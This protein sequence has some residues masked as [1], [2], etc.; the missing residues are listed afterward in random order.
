MS[1][2]RKIS[3]YCT[4]G[5]FLL[6]ALAGVPLAFC[7]FSGEP[8]PLY[9]LV[10]FT[11]LPALAVFS[12]GIIAAFPENLR[13]VWGNSRLRYL[14]IAAGALVLCAA[15]HLI[16]RRI[17]VEN[18]LGTLF[19]I[20]APLAVAALADEFRKLLIPFAAFGALL[21]LCSGMTSSGFTGL[22][23]NWNWT[24]GIFI[25]LL[26]GVFLLFFPKKWYVFTAGAIILFFALF[27][28]LD[29]V[30]FPRSALLAAAGA[31]VLLF[32]RRKMPEK[33]FVLL[34]TGTAI[35]AAVLF[36][37]GL[38]L[39]SL[40]DTRFQI[41]R[42]AAGAIGNNFFFGV[43]AGRFPEIIHPHLFDAG[44]FTEFTAPNIDHAHNDFL[45]LFAENGLAGAFFYLAALPVLFARREKSSAGKLG[46]WI[47]AV[48]VICGCFDQHHLSVLGAVTTALAAGLAIS[49]RRTE[50]FALPEYY[51]LTGLTAG[52]LL[53]AVALSMM[54]TVCRAT[55]LLRKGDL[56]ALK[57][58]FP[59][60][61]EYY[62][63]SM[64]IKFLPLAA[65]QAAEMHLLFFNRSESALRLLE[66]MEYLLKLKSFRHQQR[67]TGWAHFNLKN[68][69]QALEYFRKEERRSPY[70]VINARFLA[71]ALRQNRAPG[72]E[73]AQADRRFL[74]LCALRGISPQEVAAFTVRKD[75]VG[76]KPEVR[77]AYFKGNRFA[78]DG[79]FAGIFKNIAGAVGLMLAIYAMGKLLLKPFKKADLTAE[80]ACGMIISGMAALVIPPSI[81]KYPFLLLTLP[82]AYFAIAGIRRNLRT[83]LLYTL[84]FAPFFAAMLLPVS[85]WDEQV[86]QI[87][88]LKRYLAADSTLPV[89]DNPYS[90]Y[91]SL[92]QLFLMGGMRTGLWNIPAVTLWILTVI[93]TAK[94]RQFAKPYG[95]ILSAVAL[96]AVVLSPLFWN[97]IRA[98]YV[99]SIVTFFGFAGVIL[100]FARWEKP[101]WQYLF[102]G[103]MAG[104]AA[105]VKLPGVSVSLMLFVLL[106]TD[107]EKRRYAGI[108]IT[109]AI[110]AALPFYLRVWLTCGNPVYPY[111][112]G[113][114]GGSESSLAVETFYRT[115]GGN[116]GGNPFAGI[117]INLVATI[118]SDRDFDGINPGFQQLVFC[119]IIAAA[120]VKIK[121]RYTLLC[122]GVIA[123]AAGWIFW[124]LSAQQS[125]F[126]YPLLWAGAF[127]GVYAAAVF[128]VKFRQLAGIMLLTAAGLNLAVKSGELKHYLLAPR[129]LY[130]ARKSPADFAAWINE[131]PGYA[132]VVRE[133]NRL[134]K[135][136]IAS[137]WERRTL[138]LPENVTVIMPGAQEKFTPVPADAGELYRKLQEFDALLFRPPLKDV[139]KAVEFAPGAVEINAMIFELLKNGKLTILS[140][141][142]NGQILILRIVP[143]TLPGS[144]RSSS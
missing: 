31:G 119:G 62:G 4:A 72:N 70:S 69:P 74:E 42:G 55:V 41:W 81:L 34:L 75:D 138:Y 13:G 38:M 89:P 12:L 48:M 64:E 16:C 113:I 128:P 84:L 97:I 2:F 80:I 99:E 117:V 71:A 33:R 90:A 21:L 24:S 19:Y 37:T 107:K 116:Y 83:V 8:L 25:A 94:F 112:A 14:I 100:I 140:T 61:V 47:A 106:L 27:Y 104:A 136:R 3:R 91:P 118:F 7:R 44:W 132:E 50:K 28:A 76:F 11:T 88:L 67:L 20:S 40:P 129:T 108:F 101:R 18:L 65:Y 78:F 131:E 68:F 142:S 57:E 114:F 123:L 49:P 73:I 126:L 98:Y 1:D 143:E 79:I 53:T 125:R 102:A 22:T 130:E 58:K 103:V 95:K 9:G 110:T 23:G 60:A 96:A 35:A 32:I 77:Q 26:P 93:M 5:V 30:R 124:N 92:G 36:L 82:G 139:D 17:T 66:K 10:N 120:M 51:R 86:Y 115:L 59:Q 133:V 109:G 29:P 45:N 137:L 43:G 141:D 105:A 134:A 46:W 127:L 56:A 144:A 52:V 87:A 39:I 6:L 122:R 63:E 15:G 121:C 85:A 54:I 135:W 111:L